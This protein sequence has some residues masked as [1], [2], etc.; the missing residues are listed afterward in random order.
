MIMDFVIIREGE[1]FHT[2]MF[3]LYTSCPSESIFFWPLVINKE[4]DYPYQQPCSCLPQCLKMHE[5]PYEMVL[6]YIITPEFTVIT[7]ITEDWASFM[8]K[9]NT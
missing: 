5:K 6:Q 1:T 2:N 4:K 7:S 8:G 9:A 3:L